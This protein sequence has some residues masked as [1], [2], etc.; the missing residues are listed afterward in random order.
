MLLLPPRGGDEERSF[1]VVEARRIALNDALSRVAAEVDA[2]AEAA[3]LES[4]SS[5]PAQETTP[6]AIS[7]AQWQHQR[8]QRSQ[9]PEEGNSAAEASTAAAAATPT[10][11]C[12]PSTPSQPPRQPKPQPFLVEVHAPVYLSVLPPSS[13]TAELE[14]QSQQ[15]QQRRA[16]RDAAGDGGGACADDG[17]AGAGADDGASDGDNDARG[18]ERHS[19]TLGRQRLCEEQW[20]PLRHGFY[21]D[22]VRARVCVRAALFV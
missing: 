19:T 1:A 5:P 22:D 11:L 7:L 10:P 9:R 12:E 18:L 14:R 8:H 4:P 3:D 20:L 16:A 21:Q 13:D 2:D 17:G 15:Q 6:V